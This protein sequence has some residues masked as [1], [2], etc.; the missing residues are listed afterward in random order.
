MLR[1]TYSLDREAKSFLAVSD[2]PFVIL[3][4]G[5]GG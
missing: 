3:S 5:D 2:E 1:P 4:A